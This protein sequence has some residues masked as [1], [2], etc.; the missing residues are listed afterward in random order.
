MKFYI[1]ARCFRK[2][3]S[4]ELQF[5]KMDLYVVKVVITLSRWKKKKSI[6]SVLDQT[7]AGN[8]NAVLVILKQS[9][10]LCGLINLS[11]EIWPESPKM[12]GAVR[13]KEKARKRTR[14]T[15]SI[16]ENQ[17]RCL[18]LRL[19]WNASLCSPSC[20]LLSISLLILVFFPIWFFFF[21]C[22]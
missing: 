21:F 7:C 17:S 18:F 4:L 15:E 11:D 20:F 10:W 9:F 3:K 19:T 22:F 16:T 14:D 2:R 12:K 1:W 5:S 6:L 13:E 8:M